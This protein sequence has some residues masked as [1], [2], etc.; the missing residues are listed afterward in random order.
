M[1]VALIFVLYYIGLSKHHCHGMSADDSSADFTPSVM[2]NVSLDFGTSDFRIDCYCFTSS[3][4]E[5]ASPRRERIV[6]VTGYRPNACRSNS[7]LRNG[8]KLI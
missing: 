1:K 7:Y 3:S 8:K 6:V 5:S 2:G 4:F